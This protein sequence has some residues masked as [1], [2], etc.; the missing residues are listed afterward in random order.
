MFKQLPLPMPLTVD[1][2]FDDFYV[3]ESNTVVLAA[4]KHFCQSRVAGNKA[5]AHNMMDVVELDADV[6]LSD[7]LLFSPSEHFFYLW[8]HEGS[9]VTHVLE[10]LQ[11]LPTAMNVQYL[12]VGSMLHSSPDAAFLGLD[13]VDLLIIDDVHQLA[14]K[15]SWELALFT[16]YNRLRDAGKQLLVGSHIAPRELAI[17][18][19][20]LQSRFQWGLSYQLHSLNDDD[21]KQALL[22]RADSLG[23]RLGEGV[24]QF[25]LNHCSRDLR[26]LMNVLT[27]M[28]KETLSEQRHL[29]IPFVKQILHL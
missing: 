16:L 23:M 25:I 10:A 11:A 6:R 2:S 17:D 7:N 18:L 1:T 29:T 28:D 4:L 15:A 26:Q 9:G 20:D 13:A 3:S 14:G 12:S 8:G 24:M 5:I 19:P 27:L 21:K 22:L